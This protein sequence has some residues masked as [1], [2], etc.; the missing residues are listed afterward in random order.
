MM[1]SD[2]KKRMAALRLLI[3]KT[4]SGSPKTDR[5]E[6]LDS[7][8]YSRQ[9]NNTDLDFIEKEIKSAVEFFEARK[10]VKGAEKNE[11]P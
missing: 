5:L 2:I 6:Q 3:P 7:M 8:L 9:F 1:D 10:R 11:L 4:K